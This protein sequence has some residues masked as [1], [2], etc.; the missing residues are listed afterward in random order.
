VSFI[1]LLDVVWF[2]G[3]G[4]VLCTDFYDWFSEQRS[5]D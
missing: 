4:G 3:L 5:E 1:N 2:R